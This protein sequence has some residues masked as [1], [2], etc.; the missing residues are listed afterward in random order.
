[1]KLLPKLMESE[2]ALIKSKLKQTQTKE[3]SGIGMQGQEMTKE[4]ILQTFKK[5]FDIGAQN[6]YP[7]FEDITFKTIFIPLSREEAINIKLQHQLYVNSPKTFSI[8]NS[9]NLQKLLENELKKTNWS[10]VFIKL[11]TR[12]PKDSQVLL[13]RGIEA[14]EKKLDLDKPEAKLSFISKD[15]NAKISIFS[16]FVQDNFYVR[17]ANEAIEVLISSD[18]VFEDLDYAFSLEP[19]FKY[20]QASLQIVFREWTSAIPISREFRGFVWDFSLNAI[21]QYYH[22]LYFEE[23]FAKKK[24]I[25]EKISLFFDKNIRPRL[26]ESLKCCIVDFAIDENDGLKLIEINPF[27]GKCLASLKGSTGLFDLENPADLLTI[28]K[29][30]LELRIRE[31]QYVDTELK[32]KLNVSWKETLKKYI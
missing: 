13:N 7:I 9:S 24:I 1:M 21:G 4:E 2:I 23:L 17:N 10:K 30:P 12:S 28:Q 19:D 20:E 15:L 5:Y 16:Q 32:M 11:S 29:G 8:N 25:Q 18:R 6:W 26:N 14:L 3:P 27:D 22:S 31:K